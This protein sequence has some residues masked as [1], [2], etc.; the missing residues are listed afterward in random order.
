MTLS[1]EILNY[2]ARERLTQQELADRVGI[3]R[4]TLLNAENGRQVSRLTEAKIRLVID[5]GD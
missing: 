1:Q 2:R 3:D 4:I 5:G